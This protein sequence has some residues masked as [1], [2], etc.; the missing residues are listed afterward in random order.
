MLLTIVPKAQDLVGKIDDV[1]SY[2]EY[3]KMLAPASYDNHEIFMRYQL[4]LTSISLFTFQIFLQA[5]FSLGGNWTGDSEEK[6]RDIVL[7]CL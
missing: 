1:V 7:K 3:A 5:L 2:Y 6:F 4:S